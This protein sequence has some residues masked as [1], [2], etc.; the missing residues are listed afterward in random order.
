[1][2]DQIRGPLLY[3]CRLPWGEPAFFVAPTKKRKHH[4]SQAAVFNGAI[5]VLHRLNVVVLEKV[6]GYDHHLISSDLWLAGEADLVSFRYPPKPPARTGEV[7]TY[8]ASGFP[9][10]GNLCC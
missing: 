8:S 3:S 4:A 7:S 9:I 1:V 6:A 2:L 5:V 10:L